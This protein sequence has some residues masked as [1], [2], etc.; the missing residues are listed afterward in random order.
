MRSLPSSTSQ[1]RANHLNDRLSQPKQVVYIIPG[2]LPF[3]KM[4]TTMIE[5]NM[6]PRADLRKKLDDTIAGAFVK[7]GET[8]SPPKNAMISGAL[9]IAKPAKWIFRD[10]M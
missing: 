7:L 4:T 9:F 3:E 1:F 10:L 2:A 5:E 8:K 6:M